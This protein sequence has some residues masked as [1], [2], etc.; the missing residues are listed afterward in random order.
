MNEFVT[1]TMALVLRLERR[2]SGP[3]A[4]L[5]FEAAQRGETVIQVPSLVFAEI[6]YL[7]D[8]GRIKTSLDQ[9]ENYLVAYPNIRDCPMSFA[10]IQAASKIDDIR[11]LH[12]RLIAG[13]AVSLGVPL[14]TNDPVI[15]ASRFVKTVW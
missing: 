11:E 6:L 14:I 13:T 4:K 5:L 8:K 15:I 3:Q 1:D 7:F 10:M 2:K 9:L 12:D